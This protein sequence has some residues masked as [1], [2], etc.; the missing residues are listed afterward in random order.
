MNSGKILSTTPISRTLPAFQFI[1]GNR[2][3]YVGEVTVSGSGQYRPA[4]RCER[5]G[6]GISNTLLVLL[7]RDVPDDL[8][9]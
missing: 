7:R 3:L 4:T 5:L 1:A 2:T 9:A 6:D 8:D